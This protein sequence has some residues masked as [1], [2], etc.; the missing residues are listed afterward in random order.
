MGVHVLDPFY[1]VIIEGCSLQK[2]P[3]N[4][5][6][7]I[8]GTGISVINT[9]PSTSDAPFKAYVTYNVIKGMRTGIHYFNQ[10]SVLKLPGK[11]HWI[12]NNLVEFQAPLAP[13]EKDILS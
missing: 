4:T 6:Y 11:E 1:P 7:D 12:Y 9:N 13:N 3:L 10:N 8:A 2:G 5:V